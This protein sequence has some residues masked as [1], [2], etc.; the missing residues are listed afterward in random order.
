[1]AARAEPAPAPS[2][3][4]AKPRGAPRARP[5]AP[6]NDVLFAVVGL[7]K[8]FPV[9]GGLLQRTIAQVRAVDKVTFQ[10]K[11]GETLA[12][13]GE[14]GCGKTTMGRLL[15]HLIQPTDGD[16]LF[17]VPSSDVEKVLESQ[18]QPAK[19]DGSAERLVEKY[20]LTRLGRRRMLP[21][22][23]Y[24]QPVFQDPFTS[25]DPRML[26]KD[27]VAEPILI[28][29]LMTKEEAYDRAGQLLKE[30][31]L[32]PEH[33]Y[34]FPHEFS[35]GQRQR[36]AVARALAPSPEF[37][38]LDEPTSAL[39]VSVQAQILNLLKDIQRKQQ[40]TYLL[41]THNLSVVKQM[42]DRVAVMYLGRIMEEAPTTDLFANPLHPYT[43]ALLAAVPVPDPKRKRERIILSGDVPSPI[44]P[45]AG[46]RFHTRC[47][48]AF[49]KCGWNPE[50]ISDRAF[51]MFDGS[52][53]SAAAELPALKEVTSEPATMHLQFAQPPTEAHRA[54]V[55]SL[56]K[57]QAEEKDG[58]AFRAIARVTLHGDSIDL[59]FPRPAEPELVE[60]SANHR[61]AC[62]LYPT[63]IHGESAW[64]G[65]AP[66]SN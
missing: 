7:R 66:A 54:L 44:A 55:E 6:K 30:V 47:S 2:A 32:G 17:N 18:R 13:V 39:D 52:R 11:R 34:R 59:E 65:A 21:Y 36:I 64:G 57:A 23:R 4:T 31:G 61:V 29:H 1:V 15:L 5:P 60:V 22:R 8:H 20:S 50:D 49:E 42:S 24:M 3:P 14:S 53:N 25:L 37:L 51:F 27:I 56:V 62:F 45:P 9:K 12:L 38:M 46:C 58:L 48:A 26:I 43:K 41:I 19:T 35:G 28:N 16:V 63:G 10:I 40:L 33:L